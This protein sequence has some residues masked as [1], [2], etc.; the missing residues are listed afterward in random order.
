MKSFPHYKQADQM[1]CGPTCL[2]I[3]AK[4]Y[5]RNYS[6]Q[7]LREISG[8]NREGVSL[9]GISEAA[10]KIGFRTS[11]V[12]LSLEKL[13]EIDL[14][15]IVHWQQKHFVVLYKINSRSSSKRTY[16]ISDPARGLIEYKESE[17]LKCWLSTQNNGHSEG[18]A[19]ILSAAP[20]FYAQGGDPSKGLDLSYMLSYLYKYKKLIVQLFVG[21]G[22][23]SLLQLI[24]PFLTQ[25]VVD[26]G[27]N[28]R[29]LNF[30]YI[31]LIAQTMLFLGRMSV[32][33]I[34]SWILLH[35]TTRIN[36]SILTD[37]LIKLMKLP[38]SFFETKMTGDIMQRMSDQGRIQSFLTGSSLGAIFSLFNLVAFAFV[39]AYYNINIFI[40]FLV[41]S[42]LYSLWVIFFLKKRRELDFKRFDISSE[43][44]SNIVQ[45]ISGMQEIK[46]NNCEQQKRWEWERIQ[47]S[48]FKFSMKSLALGQ[49]QQFG[50]FFINEGKNIL[51]TFMVAKSVIDGQL[52]LGAMMAIQYIVGQLNSPIEQLLGFLQ[53]FQDAKISLERLNEI[54]E[55]EDE[56]PVER[57]FLRELPLSKNISLQNIVFTYPGAG[58]EPVLQ[59]ISLNIPEGKTT[60]IVGMSGSGKT[61]ILKLLLRF[62]EPEKGEIKVG[63]TYLQ[64]IGYRHWRGKC[65]IVMQDGFI[66]S[67]TIARNIAVGD[68][69]P[70]MPK[71][72][73]A[74][75]VANIREFIEELPLGLNT[76]IG[77]A[78]NGISQGQRQRML[79]ARAVYKDPEYI[80]FDEATNALDANNEKVIMENLETFFKGRTVVVVAHRL[81]TVKHADNIIVLE[82]G[83]IIE[84]G[85]HQEL[86][87]ANGEY[88]QL[89]KNQLELGI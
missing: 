5:G 24:L 79:I 3:V 48:L 11:G 52:T 12:R 27:I 17:F 29:N 42:V 54:H 44:Q 83:V 63:S 21:L 67:D 38:L 1:D 66:F 30:V 19:L 87:N 72:L 57:Q 89:V 16:H 13:L 60:A 78:G 69:Y 41:S 56:E 34:R 64:Q 26:I 62:Y 37:F 74:T 28:T 10:E 71:L 58:N 73:H 45:L 23:G 77:A 76:K 46:L 51:I 85:T 20:E 40:I 80:F 25:S 81:S 39:L 36:I 49:Y 2:R 32:D 43:N 65:G 82:K 47:A 4:H 75:K 31:I 55:L 18:I 6:L 88:Y 68:E 84:Q 59:N 14:P 33:F 35:I 53:S 9:L 22:V 7:R 8:I 70:D 50:A 15:C 61:T 86:V